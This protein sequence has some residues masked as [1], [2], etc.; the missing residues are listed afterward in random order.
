MTM[1]SIYT[2]LPGE[3]EGYYTRVLL[4]LLTNTISKGSEYTVITLSNDALLDLIRIL[5]EGET[6]AGNH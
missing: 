5:K 1:N 6:N 2:V 4:S 3:Q